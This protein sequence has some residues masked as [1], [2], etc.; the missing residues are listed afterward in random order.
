MNILRQCPSFSLVELGGCV[1]GKAAAAAA[2]AGEGGDFFM[3]RTR[4]NAGFF[5]CRTVETETAVSYITK[6]G[7]ACVLTALCNM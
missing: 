3:Y 2:A 1:L 6:H 7:R 4:R 5:V